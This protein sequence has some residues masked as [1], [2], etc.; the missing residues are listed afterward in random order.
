MIKSLVCLNIVEAGEWNTVYVP[1]TPDRNIT[2]GNTFS[3][4]ENGLLALEN[5]GIS[6]GAWSCNAWMQKYVIPATTGWEVYH[7]CYCTVLLMQVHYRVWTGHTCTQQA[8]W[9]ARKFRQLNATRRWGHYK[10]VMAESEGVISVQSETKGTCHTIHFLGKTHPSGVG[11]LEPLTTSQVEEMV[12]LRDSQKSMTDKRLELK[13]F[14]FQEWALKRVRTLLR[15]IHILLLLYHKTA[16][17]IRWDHCS[18]IK[19]IMQGM[20][21][22]YFKKLV[23]PFLSPYRT[24]L[25]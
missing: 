6:V 15:S 20:V 18:I 10:W 21:K 3:L 12:T 7:C 25:A 13:H 9:S 11:L 1:Q 24:C 17:L 4:G 8:K 2:I 23:L 5:T 14:H 22:I 16:L 19:N